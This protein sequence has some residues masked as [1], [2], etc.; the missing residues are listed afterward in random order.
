VELASETMSILGAG[1][2]FLDLSGDLFRQGILDTA[3]FGACFPVK[4]L[5]IFQRE[6]LPLHEFGSDGVHSGDPPFPTGAVLAGEFLFPGVFDELAGASS[7][8]SAE[9]LMIGQRLFAWAATRSHE[10]AGFF[11]NRFRLAR[12]GRWD[13]LAQ[14]AAFC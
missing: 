12:S 3:F 5:Q 14:W 8:E 10:A 2:R 11:E 1:C 4:I 7:M 9:G 13:L 6:F